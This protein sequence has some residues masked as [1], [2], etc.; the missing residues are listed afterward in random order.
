MCKSQQAQ[1]G[2][3]EKLSMVSQK[4][5][6][7]GLDSW[8]HQSFLERLVYILRAEV[9]F[10]WMDRREEVIPGD[11]GGQ[12]ENWSQSLDMRGKMAALGDTRQS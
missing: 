12:S 3:G 11:G 1:D 2:T 8:E 10:G 9:E 4:G 6:E 7:W 5:D